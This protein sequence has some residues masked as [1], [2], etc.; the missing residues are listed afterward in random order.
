VTG[1]ALERAVRAIAAG[2][3]V[4]IATE[5]FFGLCADVLD[6][7]AVDSVFALKGRAP[8]EPVPVLIRGDEDLERLVVEVP[9]P[10]RALMERYWPGPLTIVLRARP[11]VPALACGSTGTIGVR[12]PGACPAAML[13]RRCGRPLTATSANR[14]GEVPRTAD[15]DVRADFGDALDVIVPGTAPGGAPSTVVDATVEPFRIVRRGA[16]RLPEGG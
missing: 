14:S 11:E 15:A 5:S 4:A 1:D 16:V 8:S 12:V 6:A 7:G 10:A 9:T 3:V 2:G 13:L